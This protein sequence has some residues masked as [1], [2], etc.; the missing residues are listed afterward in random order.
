MDRTKGIENDDLKVLALSCRMIIEVTGLEKDYVT[1]KEIE[2]EIGISGRE[3]RRFVEDV[4]HLYNKG[5]MPKL[6][7]GNSKGY[8]YTDDKELIQKAINARKHQFKSMA[9]NWYYVQKKIN[10]DN[11]LTIDDFL[12]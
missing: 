9:Y 3:F 4:L 1:S 10:R 8:I 5:L 7:I 6:I 12:K 11:N 2:K